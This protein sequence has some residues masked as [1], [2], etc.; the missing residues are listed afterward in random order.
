MVTPTATNTPPVSVV[1]YQI[2]IAQTPIAGIPVMVNAQSQ[3]TDDNGSIAV[4]MDAGK[5]YAISSGLSAVTFD[6]LYESGA[7][8][9]A[10]GDQVIEAG[11]LVSVAGPACRIL[12]GTTPSVYFSTVNQTDMT[13]V[14]SRIYKA[15]R[16]YSV[17]GSA[18]PP[19]YFAP[20]T[21]GFTVAESAFSQNG[22]LTGVWNFL[23]QSVV[24][25]SGLSMC[26]DSG[27]PA[28]CTVVSQ[29]RL[30]API[31]Y[32]RAIVVRLTKMVITLAK[33]GIWKSGQGTFAAPFFGRGASAMA[34]MQ[35]AVAPATQG[36]AYVCATQPAASCKRVSLAGYKNVAQRHFARLFARPM[37]KG[38]DSIVKMGA[39]E[40][41]AFKSTTI[42]KLPNEVWVCPAGVN[43]SGN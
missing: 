30:R 18:S 15:N 31:M 22:G 37:P 4:S 10:R 14:V 16:M 9:I 5:Y 21:S 7:N 42:D 25:T 29:D 33:K 11:R 34:A 40:G 12:V 3:V 8:F 39:Q 28:Q 35:Q 41:R 13:H 36:T 1:N 32:T 23:G 26:A 20:G 6:A 43:P 19:D 38:L 24:V 27:A 17:T 2:R